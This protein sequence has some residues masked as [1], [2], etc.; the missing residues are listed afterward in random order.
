MRRNNVQGLRVDR[1]LVGVPVPVDAPSVAGVSVAPEAS[2]SFSFSFSFAGSDVVAAA[3]EV[4]ET[5][6]AGA[7]SPP[8]LAPTR[9]A[10]CSAFCSALFSFK[11]SF[12]ALNFSA[13][14]LAL[15]S[16]VFPPPPPPFPVDPGAGD[17]ALLD[18]A[19]EE[20]LALPNPLPVPTEVTEAA[21]GVWPRGA[22]V[23]RL[24][25][26]CP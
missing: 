24:D 5:V 14:S 11:R 22:G 15:S 16:S 9:F 8:S 17:G 25:T 23:P 20:P 7:S 6:R 2:F 19:I 13:F 18:G 3:A 1:L 12:F 21:P 10:L 26:S 4:V